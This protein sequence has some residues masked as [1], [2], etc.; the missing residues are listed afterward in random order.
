MIMKQHLCYC[1]GYVI[2]TDKTKEK[3]YHWMGICIVRNERIQPKT[4]GEESW[5]NTYQ[6]GSY[7]IMIPGGEI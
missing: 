5:G 3:T 1:T 7:G 4:A 2:E 6:G